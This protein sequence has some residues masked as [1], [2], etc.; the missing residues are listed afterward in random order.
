MIPMNEEIYDLLIQ[1]LDRALAPTERER[2]D[3]ALANSEKLQ[4]ERERLIAMRASLEEYPYQF[5]PFF[6]G[7]VM[8]QLE[9]LENP[10]ASTWILAFRQ[11][12]LPGLALL[13]ALLIFTWM[14]DGS[15]S[16]EIFT[17]VSAFEQEE[18]L[19]EYFSTSLDY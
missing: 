7:R 19:T 3:Q 10:F 17:G 2:L 8:N 16:W 11:I 4:K 6:V 14:K 15:L 1:S 18:L 13:L 9:K 12:A 5:K